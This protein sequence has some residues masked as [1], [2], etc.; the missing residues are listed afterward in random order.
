MP[1]TKQ[2][3]YRRE[4]YSLRNNRPLLFGGSGSRCTDRGRDIAALQVLSTCWVQY[5][6]RDCC[7]QTWSKPFEKDSKL[8]SAKHGTHRY[9]SSAIEDNSLGRLPEI[10]VLYATLQTATSRIRALGPAN[11]VRYTHS[12]CSPAIEENVLGR[13]PEIDVS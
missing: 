5:R 1:E 11:A 9:C 8:H 4:N 3:S 12:H 7:W 6:S 2:T 10:D 13:L